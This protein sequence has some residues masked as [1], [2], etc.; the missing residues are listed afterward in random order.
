MHFLLYFICVVIC[1]LP[2]YY[3]IHTIYLI[4]C[5][6]ISEARAIYVGY[7]PASRLISVLVVNPFQNKELSP[8]IL[9]RLFR[10]A[11]Q[12][13]SFQHPN[14]AE[15][16]SFKVNFFS[17]HMII[18]LCIWLLSSLNVCSHSGR[19]CWTCQGCWEEHAKNDKWLQVSFYYLLFFLFLF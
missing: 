1:A 17:A 16:M 5:F 9:E 4:S 7:F 12:A 6:S 10:E 14:S 3:N 13:L 15:R 8:Q 2:L 11:C 18:F 19:V